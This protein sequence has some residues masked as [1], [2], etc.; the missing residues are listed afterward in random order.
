VG[1]GGGGGGAGGGAPPPAPPPDVDVFIEGDLLHDGER[2]Q[3]SVRLVEALSGSRLW[4]QAFAEGVAER[5]GFGEGAIREMVASIHS[6]LERI[7]LGRL[8]AMPASPPGGF[9]LALLA[10]AELNKL[11]RPSLEAAARLARQ[12]QARDA[13]CALA[14]RMLAVARVFQVRMGWAEDRSQ[15]LAEARE[16]A[17]EA[18]ALDYG[19]AVAHGASGLA[20]LWNGAHDLALRAIQRGLD[21]NP[22]RTDLLH[23]KGLAHDFGGEHEAAISCHRAGLSMAP[24]HPAAFA[25]ANALAGAY[26]QLGGYQEAAGWARESIALCPGYRRSHAVLA[27]S[28]ARLGDDKGCASALA[29][30]TAL[31][32][33]LSLKAQLAGYI[34]KDT[35][36]VAAWE[37][38]YRRAGLQ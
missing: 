24:Q 14:F 7:E 26:Y 11:T 36:S 17:G 30:A 5:V 6:A 1:G 3:L 28:L 8:A 25:T 18:L 10:R 2:F 20:H 27:A 13:A 33:G 34:Y 35:G 29:R 4:E 31:D 32:P 37:R 23:W 38:G 19:D 22:S 15:A 21:L 9:A 12:A 16:A